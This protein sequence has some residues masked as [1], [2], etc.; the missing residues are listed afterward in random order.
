MIVIKRVIG[1]LI[2]A[3]LLLIA[4]AN[5][6]LAS[7]D[8]ANQYGYPTDYLASD[9]SSRGF[10]TGRERP[11]DEERIWSNY[12]NAYPPFYSPF[13]VGTKIFGKY[14]PTYVDE[15]ALM[16]EEVRDARSNQEFRRSAYDDEFEKLFA[17]ARHEEKL[18]PVIIPN[19]KRKAAAIILLVLL[20]L[21]VLAV[22]L[23]LAAKEPEQKR[24]IEYS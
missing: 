16:L 5:A 3:S 21:A 9:Y 24:I 8:A 19:Q 7:D 13:L 1:I 18:Q 15:Y 2:F 10:M 14:R 23:L 20:L 11:F 17:E 22:L 6:V 12:P 4:S